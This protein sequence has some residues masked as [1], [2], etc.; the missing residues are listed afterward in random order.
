MGTRWTA[1]CGCVMT[2]DAKPNPLPWIAEPVIH[3]YKTE[4]SCDEHKSHKRC[5]DRYNA[6]LKKCREKANGR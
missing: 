5:Q 6:M 1:D 4:K 3:N 2:Y